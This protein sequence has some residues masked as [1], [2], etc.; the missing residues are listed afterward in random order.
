MKKKR[1]SNR[2]RCAVVA[3]TYVKLV[4]QVNNIYENDKEM[5]AEK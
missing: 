5:R 1:K 2:S 4:K 3:T